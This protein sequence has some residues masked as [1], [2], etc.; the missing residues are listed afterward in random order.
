[1]TGLTIVY[2]IYTLVE[3]FEPMTAIIG[4][5]LCRGREE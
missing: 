5:L 1:L 4:L 3:S 2:R